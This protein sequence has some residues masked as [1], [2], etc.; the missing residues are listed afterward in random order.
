MA[1]ARSGEPM[2]EQRYWDRLL[3]AGALIVSLTA[4]A[5]LAYTFFL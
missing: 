3:E 4:I 5:L 1:R 2:T